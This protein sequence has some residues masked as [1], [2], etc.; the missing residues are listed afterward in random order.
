MQL[1]ANLWKAN[2]EDFDA[3]K[4][5]ALILIPSGSYGLI[6]CDDAVAKV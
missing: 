3:S 4:Q 5:Y 6:I 2:L 1:N